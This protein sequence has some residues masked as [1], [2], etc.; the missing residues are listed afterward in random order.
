MS[1]PQRITQSRPVGERLDLR[2]QHEVLQIIIDNIP[3]MIRFVGPD[4]RVQLVNRTWEDTLGWSLEELQ[5]DQFELFDH[6]FPDPLERERALAFVAAATGEWADF[7]IRVR[8]GRTIDATFASIRLSDGTNISIGQDITERKRAERQLR[9]TAEQLR[10]LS[11]RIN[12][13]KEEEGIRIAREIHDELGGALTRLR[14]D[15]WSLKNDLSE[16]AD[17]AHLQ[18]AQEKTSAM[19]TLTDAAIDVVRRIASDLRPD[20]LDDLGLA[21]AIEWQ[22]RQF[23]LRSGL[24]C[25]C[26]CSLQNLVLERAQ[27][28]AV[29]R[30]FQEALTNILRHAQATKVEV[31]LE[32]E[33][34]EVVLTIRDDGRGFTEEEVSRSHALGLLGMQE[35]VHSI[36]GKVLVTGRKGAGTVVTVRI[37]ASRE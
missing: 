24:M 36:G 7:R 25:Q 11:A 10:A 16:P 34:G 19:L 32:E 29:F 2:H 30:I 5:Q 8:D 23:Q 15:L 26:H 20:G 35:R 37:P 12:S 28:T 9:E 22:C 27:T 31:S 21:E 6:L 1:N 14:W 3:V 4:A 18:A 17:R 13:V 33:D